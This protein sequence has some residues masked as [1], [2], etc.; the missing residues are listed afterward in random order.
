MENIDKAFKAYEN[1]LE[2]IKGYKDT[3]FTEQDT[4][5][6]IVDRILTEVL[7]V[8]YDNIQTESRTGKGFLDYKVTIQRALPRL[9]IE[10]KKDGKNF[11]IH[12]SKNGRHY[13]LNGPVFNLDIL[14]D[15]IDQAIYYCA[16]KSVE[17]ACLTNGISWIV[18][19]ANRFGDGKDVTDGCAVVFDS[20]EGIKN[21]FKL[22][23][24]LLSYE[25]LKD[26]R[27]RAIFQEFEGITIRTKTEKHQLVYEGNIRMLERTEHSYDF[28]RIMN[29]FFSKLIG[30]DDPNLLVEC[31]VHSKESE[32]A[33]KELLRVSEELVKRMRT[34]DT[35]DGALLVELIDRVKQSSRHEFVIIVG[36]KGAGKS[37]FVERFFK[38]VLPKG[39]QEEC[40]VIKIN[41]ALSEGK[42]E[43]IV[44]WLNTSLLE[45]TERVLFN[46]TPTYEQ[47]QGI[48]YHEYERL[49]KGPWKH[50]YEKDKD[51]FKVDFGKH[52]EGRRENKSN[53]HIKRLIGDI[54]KSRKK[55]PCIIFDNT[56]HF[57]I[58]FQEKVFQYARSIYE[59]EVCLIIIPITEKTSWQLSKEGAF[60]SFENENLYLPTPSPKKIIERRIAYIDAKVKYELREKGDY[61]TSK[62]IRLKISDLSAFVASLQKILLSDTRVATWIGN[63]ANFDVRRCLELTRD[64]ISSPLIPI[65]DLLRS[66]LS[67]YFVEIRPGKI[68]FAMIKGFYN[69]YPINQHKFVQNM[70]S[71]SGHLDTSPILSCR[72]LQFLIDVK[73]E[74]KRYD[75]FISLEQTMDYFNGMGIPRHETLNH[76]DLMLKQG[77]IYNYDPTIL[78]IN[79]VKKIELSSSG[80]QHYYWALY[81]NEYMSSMME[82]TPITNENTYFRLKESRGDHWRDNLITFIEYLITEDA[83]YCAVPEHDAYKGQEL[84]KRNLLKR[85]QLLTEGKF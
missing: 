85:S 24:D 47:L 65:D 78:D 19:R 22:F 21:E 43:T 37:T 77:M 73:N 16:Y 84:L 69:H 68:K 41:L 3:L 23:F 54:T 32:Y 63:L 11:E 31:F 5:I 56:D 76:I 6:K 57:S 82:V 67:K 20:L 30:D 64:L 53:E 36:G 55:V 79:E 1:L 51:Q 62:G 75:S 71:Y 61:F 18:F 70:F 83:I 72:I 45:E 27:Y 28:D 81:D 48:F 26:Y 35:S 80:K 58:T 52:I 34:L 15:G 8:P 44:D 50:L 29:V 59:K 10:A 66:F 25:A 38:N 17:L 40:V 49:S 14:K 13:L 33:E 42:E 74:K 2:E 4:R 39:I 60:Q 12:E 9:I 46:G 7:F